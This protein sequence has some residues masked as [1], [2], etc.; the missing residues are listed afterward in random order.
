[1]SR[2]LERSLAAQARRIRLM[3]TRGVVGRIN[4]GS[5]MQG[6]QVQLLAGEFRNAQRFQNFGFSSVPLPGAEGVFISLNGSRDQGVL[7]AVDDR[8]YRKG[9]LAGGESA[10]YNHLGDYIHIKADRSI[11]IVTQQEVKVTAKRL[12]INASEKVRMVTPLLEVTG[13]IK[14][15]CDT[16]LGRLMSAMR[17]WM[18]LHTHKEND[19]GADTNQPTQDI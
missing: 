1:M 19:G 13:E 6:S 12:V 8:R 14:D 7:V 18:R 4:D 16:A 9:G 3:A 10:M 2:A 15:L 5:K 17:S 11:E